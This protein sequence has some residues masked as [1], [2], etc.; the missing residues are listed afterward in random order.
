MEIFSSLTAFFLSL[1]DPIK[2][3]VAFV[4]ALLPVLVWIWFW[5]HEEKTPEPKLL[6]CLA[7]IAGMI[8][9]VAALPL[10][11]QV[12]KYFTDLAVIIVLWASIEEL[13]KFLFAYFVVI[14][15]KKK[16]TPVDDMMYMIMTALGFAALENALFLFKPLYYGNIIEA[17][18]TGNLRFIGATL[19]H[20]IASSAIGFT[21]ALSF[22]RSKRARFVYVSIGVITAI[23]LHA[24]FNLSIMMFEGTQQIIPFYAVWLAVVATLL[25]FEKVK[26]IKPSS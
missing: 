26:S 7:L 23:V 17:V 20:T 1:P 15:W 4:S 25:A 13:L 14:R 22:Y 18:N 6:V 11:E 12:T 3:I 2:F 8:A 19:L 24:F 16:A 9:V 10:E 5:E 21:L